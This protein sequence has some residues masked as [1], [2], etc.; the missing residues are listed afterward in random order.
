MRIDFMMRRTHNSRQTVS[1]AK[2]KRKY[3][4]PL[5]G[6]HLPGAWDALNA[7][8]CEPHRAYHGWRHI[9]ALL[10]KLNALQV[11]AS[12]ADLIAIAA[13]WHDAVYT[14]RGRD[15]RPRPDSENVCDSAFLFRRYTLLNPPARDA[16]FALIMATANHLHARPDAQ[17]YDGFEGDLDLFL[18]LDLSSLAS[19]WDK[20]EA[21]LGLIR[22]EYSWASD[23]EF[24]SAHLRALQNFAGD[25]VELFRRAETRAKWQGG[26][27]ANLKRCVSELS[28]K[29][30]VCSAA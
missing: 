16:T 2:I 8:Y 4:M 9:A 21:H 12:R 23:A 26:A 1:P 30:A 20:F 3:W 15:G 22:S 14:T 18:D 5:A 11:L 7:A 13:F 10:E 27:R 28:K 6:A 19:P 29:L 24:Y 25:D 17:F